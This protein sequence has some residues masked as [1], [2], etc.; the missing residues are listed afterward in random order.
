MTKSLFVALAVLSTLT[1]TS[2]NPV[3]LT[4]DNFKELTKGK[5][6]FVKFFAPWYVVSYKWFSLGGQQN[7]PLI[8]LTVVLCYFFDPETSCFFLFRFCFW[9][10]YQGVAIANP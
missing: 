5:N 6:A 9:F 3:E 4:S 1:P 8:L 2:G 7:R 10:L